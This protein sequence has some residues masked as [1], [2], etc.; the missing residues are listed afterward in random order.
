G[1]RA[2]DRRDTPNHPAACTTA[3]RHAMYITDFRHILDESGAI[4][5]AKGPARVMAQFQAEGV[6]M[7]SNAAGQQAP[8]APR[9]FKCKK[10][11]VKACL[12][13]DSAIV[14]TCPNCGA[15]GRISNWQGSMWDLRDRQAPR[16]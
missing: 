7:V 1:Q 6:A 9:C 5:P 3:D 10:S 16:S 12:A 13:R 14:W 4:G 15:E 8:T 2:L 11:T